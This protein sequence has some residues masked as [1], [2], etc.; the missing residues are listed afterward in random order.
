LGVASDGTLYVATHGG[1]IKRS[2]TTW[3]YASND[4]N[5]HMGFSMDPK[6]GVMWRSGHSPERPSLGVETSTDGGRTWK[7]LSDVL[8]PPV[9]FH[10]MAVSLADGKTLWGWDSGRRGLFRS[11]GGRSWEKLPQNPFAYVLSGPPT[12]D[13]ILAG[14][15]D[16]M[17]RSTD[18]GTTWQ[19]VAALAGGWV[20]AIAADPSDAAKLLAFTQRGMKR[21][22][23]GGRS[24]E[25]ALGGIPPTAEITSLAI[26]PAG[27]G[28]AYAADATTIYGTTDGGVT[29]SVIRRGT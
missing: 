2:G 15:P 8:S 17:L 6:S 25:P 16:G 23:D 12:A 18:G 11:S 22:V 24:W 10:A 27:S 20:I 28:T 21:S 5:D 19:P 29:W 3:I 1:L 14:V 4:R 13:V 26:S 9:D 7:R